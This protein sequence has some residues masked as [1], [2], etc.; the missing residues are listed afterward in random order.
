MIKL[1]F[2]SDIFKS[3]NNFVFIY[4]KMPEN[5]SAK[6]YHESKVDYK[7]KLAK[8]EKE[9]TWKCDREVQEIFF[10]CDYVWKNL[11]KN[12]KNLWFSSVVNSFLKCKQ[13]PFPKI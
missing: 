8:E 3:F 4:I 7:T 6:H 5:L 11:K 2:K 1:K 13:V 10:S 12:I 9:K